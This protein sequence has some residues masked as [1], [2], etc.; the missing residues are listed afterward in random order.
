MDSSHVSLC[1]LVL[2]SDGF[3]HYV[4][5]YSSDAYK[6]DEFE[7]A[8]HLVTSSVLFGPAAL[9]QTN[10]V[11]FKLGKSG[12]GQSIAAFLSV[13]PRT[14]NGFIIMRVLEEN[15]LVPHSSIFFFSP[16]TDFE[17]LRK[18]RCGDT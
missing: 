15:Y 10:I 3:D 13:I 17:V 7:L 4:S 5:S 18:R 11:G 16:T 8:N 12:K 1:A 9:R 6:I 2:R 14:M